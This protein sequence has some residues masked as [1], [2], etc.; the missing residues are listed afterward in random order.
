MSFQVTA[1]PLYGGM[2]FR[3]AMGAVV[4]GFP[5][6]FHT[7]L[8]GQISPVLAVVPM[9]ARAAVLSIPTSLSLSKGRPPWTADNV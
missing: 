9:G 6:T 5:T 2:R 8:S 3:F 1:L 4:E 7:P